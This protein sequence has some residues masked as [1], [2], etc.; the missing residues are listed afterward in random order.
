MAGYALDNKTATCVSDLS[1]NSGNGSSNCQIC[2][3]LYALKGN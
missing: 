1:C 3:N 2:P